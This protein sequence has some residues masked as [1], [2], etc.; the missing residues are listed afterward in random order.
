MKRQNDGRN[1]PAEHR[2]LWTGGW[3]STYRVLDLILNQGAVVAPVY[4]V[5]PGRRSTEIELATMAAIRARIAQRS[6]DAA[7][8]LRPLATY[9]LTGLRPRERFRAHLQAMRK[10]AHLGEQYVWLAE[11]L[12]AHNLAGLEL[13]IH[14]D[15]AAHRF[16]APCAAVD[17][18][19]CEIADLP[20][21]DPRSLFTGFRFPILEI[22]KP[23]MALAAESA[24]FDDILELSWFC[25]SPVGVE[26]CG[27]CNPCVFT[28]NEGLARRLPP[29][30]LFRYRFRRLWN[31]ARK[32]KRA[33]RAIMRRL[34]LRLAR[35]T[36]VGT[37]A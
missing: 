29:S 18:D 31:V 17:G 8:R 26:A 15:D 3:D 6:Q 33:P 34:S 20:E 4:V 21:A 9:D 12:A 2:V 19:V 16:V 13:C 27:V 28:V 25:H 7:A 10:E 24:G 36:S 32:I 22:T 1:K 5:D 30:A 35:T 37:P 11:L 14:K 23:E